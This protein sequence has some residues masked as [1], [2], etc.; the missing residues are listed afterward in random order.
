MLKIKLYVIL[1]ILLFHLFD[2]SCAI[3]NRQR[4]SG[5]KSNR[6]RTNNCPSVSSRGPP[7]KIDYENAACIGICYHNKLQAMEEGR[8]DDYSKGWPLNAR[9]FGPP[10]V[11][12][13]YM[14]R[15][16][17][18]TNP[19]DSFQHT[20]VAPTMTPTIMQDQTSLR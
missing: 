12:L 5:S 8:G 4:G 11:G 18:M 14:Y 1:S 13:C 16:L 7:S 2:E 9:E 6:R 20:G 19:G 15:E 3:G 10:C 17:N